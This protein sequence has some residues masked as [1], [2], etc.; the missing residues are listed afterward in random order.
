[1]TP[2]GNCAVCKHRERYRVELLLSGGASLRSVAK[3]FGVAYHTTRR[4]WQQHVSA[5]R[6]VALIAGPTKLSELADRAAEEGGS[7]LDHFIIL[8]NT[9]YRRLDACDE[10]GDA[11]QVAS[12]SGRII[13]VLREMGRLTGDLSKAGVN[14]TNNI[15]ISPQFAELQAALIETLGRHPDAR[16]DVIRAFRALEAG[17]SPQI[18]DAQSHE[19]VREYAAE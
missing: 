17:S 4:H 15:F 14:I 6:R 7:L 10:A 16:T 2:N 18:I 11:A 19:V 9:L 5:E 1:M 8:R 13:E 12:L 3:R